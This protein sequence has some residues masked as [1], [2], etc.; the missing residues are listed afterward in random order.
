MNGQ[1]TKNR[2][3]RRYGM[4]IGIKPDRIG[5]YKCLHAAAWPGV[6]AMIRECSIENYSIYLK[7]LEPGKYYLFSYFE[8]AGDDFDADMATMTADPTTQKW[9]RETAPCQ[10]PLSGEQSWV[11]MEEVFHTE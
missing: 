11:Y 5:E 9:W 8:Y 1:E 4:V 7:E 6:L 3:V 10:I 2:T